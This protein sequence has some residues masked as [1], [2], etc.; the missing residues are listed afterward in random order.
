MKSFF[1]DLAIA[2]SISF[3]LT[4]G[5]LYYKLPSHSIVYLPGNLIPVDKLVDAPEDLNVY[6]VSTLSLLIENRMD[7]VRYWIYDKK[8]HFKYMFRKLDEEKDII[9]Q[10]KDDLKNSIEAEKE[11]GFAIID[12]VFN[13]YSE[14]E[15]VQLLGDFTMAEDYY[16]DSASLLTLVGLNFLY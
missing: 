10:R 15:A 12:Y 16:G 9:E 11:A 1:R 8:I 7:F 3:V 4:S 2:I 5:Y 13:H 14:E 6:G